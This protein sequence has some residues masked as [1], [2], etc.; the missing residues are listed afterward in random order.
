MAKRGALPK[1]SLHHLLWA[2][3]LVSDNGRIG[4]KRLAALMGVGEGTCRG[5]LRELDD[6]GLV[7]V[8]KGGI[9]LSKR[10][11]RM[12]SGLPAVHGELGLGPLA[13]SDF[14]HGVAMRDHARFVRSGIEQRDAAM[15]AGAIGATALIF[16]NGALR[17]PD[18]RKLEE[19]YGADAA[20]LVHL[21][22]PGEG[23]VIVIGYGRD[24]V[25]AESGAFAAAATLAF[26]MCEA[27]ESIL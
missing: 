14:A 25:G 23:D 17:F 27:A 24:A 9:S 2:L 26:A 6:R 3:F 18:G 8:A 15:L 5:V 7:S 11:R 22:K 1:Y 12:M 20:L 19:D 4:R 13:L 10:G 16:D 21:F